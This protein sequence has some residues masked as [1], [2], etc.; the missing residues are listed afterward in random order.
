VKFATQFDASE[1]NLADLR[2]EQLDTLAPATQVL[3][4]TGAGPLDLKGAKGGGGGSEWWRTL[5]ALALI[6]ACLESVLA[7][8]FSSPK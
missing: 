2:Q 6:V 8:V 1:S 3:R 4:W 7:A 5:A